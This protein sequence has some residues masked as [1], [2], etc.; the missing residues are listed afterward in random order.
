MQ[1]VELDS[2]SLSCRERHDFHNALGRGGRSANRTIL[3]CVPFID[4][5]T[6]LPKRPITAAR[7]GRMLTWKSAAFCRCRRF[8]GSCP[9]AA[10]SRVARVLEPG[11]A[12]HTRGHPT[13]HTGRRPLAASRDRFKNNL[14]HPPDRHLASLGVNSS[15]PIS[16]AFPVK[17]SF[18]PRMGIPL[19]M[20]G[21]PGCKRKS[22]S[23]GSRANPGPEARLSR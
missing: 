20:Q 22:A 17:S 2:R 23:A 16:G 18:K 19:S 15:A 6:A 10:S 21:L 8:P 13:V 5:I 14:G 3:T 1:R 11:C 7:A 4:R 12:S 9:H